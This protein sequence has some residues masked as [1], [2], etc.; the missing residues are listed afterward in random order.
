MASI[1]IS[2]IIVC[3]SVVWNQVQQI[4]SGRYIR[5]FDIESSQTEAEMSIG[6]SL[7]KFTKYGGTAIIAGYPRSAMRILDL[8]ET[9]LVRIQQ[10]RI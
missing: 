4:C 7:I 8:T 6:T 5:T 10:I 1:A 9:N 2:L 3:V